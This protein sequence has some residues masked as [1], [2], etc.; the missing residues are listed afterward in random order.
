MPG[1]TGQVPQ[2]ITDVVKSQNPESVEIESTSSSDNLTSNVDYMKNVIESDAEKKRLDAEQQSYVEEM[3]RA[4]RNDMIA[5]SF[6]IGA[7]TINNLAGVARANKEEENLKRKMAIENM[8]TSAEG[9]RGLYDVNTGV[10]KP[11]EHT[12][13]VKKGGQIS[14]YKK[15]GTYTLDN[16]EILRLIKEGYN[17]KF[18]E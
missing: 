1:Q 7:Q 6:M 12:P 17:I 14:K 4:K 3:K 10:F 18:A 16:D 5:D 2:S 8:M 9:S 15:G 13:V 11:D